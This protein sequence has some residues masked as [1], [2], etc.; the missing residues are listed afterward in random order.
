MKPPEG[1]TALAAGAEIAPFPGPDALPAGPYTDSREHLWDELHRIDRWVRACTVRWR[2]TLGNTKPEHLWGMLHVTDTE[3]ER[4]LEAPFAPPGGGGADLLEPYLRSAETLGRAIDERRRRTP[5]EVELRLDR[6]QDLFELSELER[7][8]LLVCL[9]PEADGR[10]RRLYA[11]LQDD[12]ARTRPSVELVL[13]ILRPLCRR[14]AGEDVPA[15][16]VTAGRVLFDPQATLIARELLTF[17]AA[18]SDESLLARS[19]R[20]DDRI[21]AHLLGSDLPDARLDPCLVRPEELPDAGWLVQEAPQLARL[22]AFARWWGGSAGEPGWGAVIF[23]HGAYGSGRLASANAVCR[24]VE[25]PLLVLD[26]ERALA[27]PEPWPVLVR[28]AYREAA[29]SGVA[30]AW[31]R[32]EVL[33][34]KPEHRRRWQ[35]LV[36]AAEV[37][38]GVTFLAGA[39]PWEPA[40]S[41]RSRAFLRFDFPMPGPALRQQLWHT[42]L[43]PAESFT[44]PAPDR[45]A[46][47][48]TLANSFQLTGGQ[49]A[50]AVA[51]APAHAFQRDPEDPR[52]TT[53]DLYEGCRRQTSGQLRSFSRRVEPRTDLGFEDLV[54]P[55]ENRGQLEE[56]R[57][58]I[59]YRNRVLSGLGFDRRLGLG[60]GLVVL[61]TGSSGTGKTMAAELLAREQGVDLYKIDLS[62]VISKYVGETEKNLSSVFSQAEHAN[63]LLFFDEADALFGKR[64]EVKDARDRWANLEVNYLLQRIEEYAGVVILTS[65]L[66]QNIDEAFM[67]RI[68]VIVE[69][70]FPDAVCCLPIWRGA[71]PPDLGRPAD[72]ALR[73]LAER[74]RFSGGEIKNVVVGAAYLALA[75]GGGEAAAVELRHLVYAAAREYQKNGKPVTRSEFGEEYF[76]LLEPE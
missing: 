30:L 56:L 51:S 18:E 49:I 61:F 53:E 72:E 59:R 60:K 8:V 46:L 68:Q 24:A 67:R 34:E 54:L 4:Y 58:R 32:C 40:G 43:P 25:Q 64:G 14:L 22:D 62:S 55:P 6:L 69:F 31:R 3:V 26:A 28:R 17:A 74:F 37:F 48:A 2:L 65:N 66:R 75:E 47:A 50:D 29:L 16:E 63:A 27:C 13:E 5:E 10:Y 35:V 21:A 44:E 19:L 41:F 1:D 52:L 9:L 7:D 45:D 36:G 38:P 20:L 71:F 11:Y 57:V 33:L 70:P 42:Q 23:L 39:V 73:G 12:A 76:A 15:P